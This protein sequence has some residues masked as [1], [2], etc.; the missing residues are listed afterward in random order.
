MKK[1]SLLVIGIF[2]TI[3][4]AAQTG[5][6]Y[7]LLKPD[8]V[9]DGEQLHNDWVVLVKNQQIEQAGP[10][11]FKLPANTDIIDLKGMTLLPGLIEGH[12][13]LFLHPYNE[14]SWNDQV[15]TESRAERT[16]RAV[17]HAR[18]TLLAGFTTVRDLGTEGAMYDDVGLK[19]AIEK[20]IIPGPRM[21]CATR[22]I[23]ALGSYGVKSKNPDVSYPK[24]AAEIASVEEMEKEA[25]IQIS[26]GADLIK[27]YADYGWGRD[28]E[29][30]PTLTTEEMMM[31]V[32]I[33][34]SSH[35]PVAAHAGTAEGMKRAIDAG[36]TTIE[37]GDFGTAE[38]FAMMKEKGIAL[39][40][41]LAA[42]EAYESYKGW[43]KGIDPD[44]Q[45]IVEKKKSFSLALKAGVTICMG[46][47]VGVFSHGDNAREMELM[48]DYGMTPADVLRSATS[49]NATVFGYADKI[50]SIK[51]GLLADLI[52]VEGNPAEEIKAIRNITLVMKNGV[53]YRQDK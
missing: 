19:T 52:A 35:R 30:A 5:D 38:V 16:A 20:G 18:Q 2:Y 50:G 48:V 23:V 8:R 6:H 36:V 42:G 40:P 11:R 21:I 29:A 26:K 47:D 39:C 14:T 41:T 13:H 24:G 17:V 25:R 34:G 37:H 1:I 22:A 43:R 46:G 51:K 33:A 10:L 15:L 28:G 32:K 49:I 9:F 31:A 53:I 27:V 45:R 3:L 12:A 7:I 44:P 4:A